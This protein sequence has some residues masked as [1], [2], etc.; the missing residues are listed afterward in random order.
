MIYDVL[1]CGPYTELL[2]HL[3]TGG[4]KVVIF[5]PGDAEPFHAFGFR[6]FFYLRNLYTLFRTNFNPAKS[7]KLKNVRPAKR[8]FS[9][10][11]ACGSIPIDPFVIRVESEFI[12]TRRL[13]HMDAEFTEHL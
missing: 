9:P 4:E 12:M 13:N 11:R 7:P 10:Q 8:S 2:S 5:N 1:L 3:L 6:R